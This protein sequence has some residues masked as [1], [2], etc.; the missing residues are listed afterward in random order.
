MWVSRVYRTATQPK[1]NQNTTKT[2]LNRATLAALRIRLAARP[3]FDSA[4]QFLMS[5]MP[6]LHAHVFYDH[7]PTLL[8]RYFGLHSI[9]FQVTCPLIAPWRVCIAHI[10]C[11]G[12]IFV[13]L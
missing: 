7:R 8:S 6:L 5:I 10:V 1:H 9:S 4:P 13:L 2:L 11:R 12:R 3:L